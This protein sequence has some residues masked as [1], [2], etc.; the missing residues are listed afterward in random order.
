[1]NVFVDRRLYISY[2]LI[3]GKR[4]KKN[5]RVSLSNTHDGSLI[6]GIS[7]VNNRMIY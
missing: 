3:K 6:G 7:F 4:L 5:K 1:M 2:L